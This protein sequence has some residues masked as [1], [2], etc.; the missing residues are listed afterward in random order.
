MNDTMDHA[1]DNIAPVPT[2][3]T[4]IAVLALV[5]SC[6]SEPPKPPQPTGARR[7]VRIAELELGASAQAIVSANGIAYVG[8]G[9]AGVV[10]VDV[11]EPRAPEILARLDSVRAD[12]LAYSEDRLFALARPAGL[13]VGNKSALTPI[14]V[15]DPRA[16]IA[17]DSRPIDR[18][19]C[20][21]AAAA[22]AVVGA[23]TALHIGADSRRTI[24]RTIAADDETVVAI[25]WRGERIAAITA[26][27]V[28]WLGRGDRNAVLE[29][30][31]SK[32]VA[33]GEVALGDA[34]ALRCGDGDVAL[35]VDRAYAVAG[36]RL[37]AIATPRDGAPSLLADLALPG[38]RSLA[39]GRDFAA[40]GGEA[41]AIVDL[42]GPPTLA[43]RIVLDSPARD[44]AMSDDALLVASGDRGLRIYAVER[45]GLEPSNA[46]EPE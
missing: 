43:D 30:F 8:C 44:V 12:A 15:V 23:G 27:A 11:S 3:I 37:L 13:E 46:T 25:A 1:A 17:L 39:I 19:C 22:R 26:T 42:A 20:V 32:G 41:L 38:S 21:A 33:R 5:S 6:A 16:P 2:R 40:V 14:D 18:A 36:G 24:P 45:P 9:E 4:A 31:D 10:I 28:K 34:S 7:L 29:L 35:E